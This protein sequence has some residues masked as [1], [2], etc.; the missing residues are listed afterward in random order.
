MR[1]KYNTAKGGRGRLFLL[2][3]KVFKFT[4]G[5]ALCGRPFATA[6]QGTVLTVLKKGF[7]EGSLPSGEGGK[8]T[9][10]DG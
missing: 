6:P 10:F 9:G 3:V 1:R 5:A 2:K 4:V 7:P 8:T